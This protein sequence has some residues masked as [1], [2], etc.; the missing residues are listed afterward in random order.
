[1]TPRSTRM[2]VRTVASTVLGLLLLVTPVTG[3]AASPPPVPIVRPATQDGPVPFDLSPTLAAAKHDYAA[4][5]RDG[6]HVQQNG[7]A[8]KGASCVYGDVRSSTTIV[9]FGDSHAMH[10]FPAVDAWAR[11]AGFALVPIVRSAC[12][13]IDAPLVAPTPQMTADCATW[14]T[15]ALARIGEMVPALTVVS[16]SLGTG[17]LLDGVPVAPRNTG[18]E[19]WIAPA[20]RMLAEVRARSAAVV[21]LGDVPRPGFVVPDCLAVHRAD[22]A[23]C[24][25]PLEVVMPP[26]A[27]AAEARAAAAAGVV[28]ADPVPWLCGPDA[29]DW[30]AGDAVGWVDDQHL[31]TSG[32]LHALPELAVVLGAAIGPT[33]MGGIRPA[34]D[35]G[36]HG[37]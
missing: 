21:F 34:A 18:M 36:P 30:M 7:K 37:G 25:R 9:L 24:G 1:M 15:Q 28:F 11:S 26:V 4:P 13:P 16:G 35:P 17:V 29:C 20:T 6:C 5:Y 10:W 12:P 33:A 3:A 23:T 22:P 19:A 32:A 27:R 8:K 31:T 2:R 14:R